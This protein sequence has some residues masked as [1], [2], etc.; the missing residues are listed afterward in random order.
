[1]FDRTITE[2]KGD[3]WR[4]SVV[5]G[6]PVSVTSRHIILISTPVSHQTLDPSGFVSLNWRL[7]STP[8]TRNWLC[9]STDF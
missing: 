6:F 4:W 5:N 9:F 2:P 3:H 7:V 1:M 8:V